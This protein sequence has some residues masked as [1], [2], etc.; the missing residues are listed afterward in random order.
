MQ[1][2]TYKP[3]QKNLRFE[4]LQTSRLLNRSTNYLQRKR[5][6]TQKQRFQMR[7]ETMPIWWKTSSSKR[8]HFDRTDKYRAKLRLFDLLPVA[9]FYSKQSKD[10]FLWQIK[11]ENCIEIIQRINSSTETIALNVQMFNVERLTFNWLWNVFDLTLLNE[12]F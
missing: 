10:L 12:G 5:C 11:H 8:L 4:I 9:S 6:S 1:P 7:I 2:S 3:S